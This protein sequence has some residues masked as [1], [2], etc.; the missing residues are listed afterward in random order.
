M[1][2]QLAPQLV[3]A[4]ATVVEQRSHLVDEEV[5]DP[6]AQFVEDGIATE[7]GGIAALH[8]VEALVE[9]HRSSFLGLRLGRRT[10]GSS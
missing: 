8:L 2:L 3:L 5:V 10:F 4:D 1:L 9:G 6:L 7:L